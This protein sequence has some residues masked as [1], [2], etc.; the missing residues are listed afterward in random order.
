MVGPDAAVR[1]DAHTALLHT[2]SG[3]VVVAVLVVVMSVWIV[4]PNLPSS[5]VRDTVDVVWSPAVNAGFDQNWSVF[6]PNPRTQ[7]LE[8]VAVAEFADGTTTEWKLPEFGSVIGAYRTSRWRKWQER[9]RLDSN[10]RYWESS[11]AWIASDVAR[12]DELPVRVRLQRRWR[13]L[14]PLTADGIV[15]TELN[16]YEFFVWDRSD[17]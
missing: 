8:V 1:T 3:K 17:G 13:D 9:V 11:A 16:E 12:G 5:P 15:D 10:E 4:G 2:R 14:E 7:S 6:S